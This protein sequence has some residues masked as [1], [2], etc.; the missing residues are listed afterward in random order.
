[1][2][3]ANTKVIAEIDVKCLIVNKLFLVIPLM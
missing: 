2:K 3:N 1:M